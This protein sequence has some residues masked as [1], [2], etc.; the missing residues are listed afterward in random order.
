MKFLSDGSNANAKG[1]VC[2]GEHTP[3]HTLAEQE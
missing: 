3:Y 2:L 1:R